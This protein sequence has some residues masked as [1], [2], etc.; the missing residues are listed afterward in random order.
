VKLRTLEVIKNQMQE[1]RNKNSKHSKHL[2]SKLVLELRDKLTK[3]LEDNDSV[4]L[5]IDKKVMGE[6]LNILSETFLTVYSYEQ[7]D[8]NKFVFY[9]KEITL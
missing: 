7:V 1:K 8:V 4:S 5:E 9:H 3:H 6:F 2:E